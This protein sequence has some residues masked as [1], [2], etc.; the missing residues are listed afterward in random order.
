MIEVYQLKGVNM[1]HFISADENLVSCLVCGGLW[2]DTPE[3][4][5]AIDGEY[6]VRCTGN[7]SS[8]HH[9][10]GECPE[11]ECKLNQD[12]NCLFCNS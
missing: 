7:T 6:A 11:D 2:Q 1:H 8:C 4:A 12:C 10:S 5:V 3:G 9:Y